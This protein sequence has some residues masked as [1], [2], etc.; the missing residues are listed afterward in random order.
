MVIAM[1]VAAFVPVPAASAASDPLSAAQAKIT[2]AQ[3]AADKAAADYD[4]AQ[5]RYYQLQADARRTDERIAS[6]HQEVTQLLGIVRKRAILAYMGGSPGPLD[7]LL[8]SSS[9]A[10]SAS[11][12]L[13]IVS[14]S[15]LS[16]N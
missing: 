10:L 11:S 14:I 13:R 4:A 15:L 8:G 7:G 12:T 2:A 1:T 16:L 6:L 9:D 3:V 5:A